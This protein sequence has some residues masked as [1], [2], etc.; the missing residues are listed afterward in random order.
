MK[1]KNCGKDKR[2]V[3]ARLAPKGCERLDGDYCTACCVE[4]LPNRE[5][6]RAGI[7]DESSVLIAK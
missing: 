1:C 3:M 6:M 2:D 5:W 4:V 7:P